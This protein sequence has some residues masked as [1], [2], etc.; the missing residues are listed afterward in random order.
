MTTFKIEPVIG[1]RLARVLADIIAERARQDAK[2]GEQNH[3]VLFNLAS[4]QAYQQVAESWKRI[5]DRRVGERNRDGFPPDKNAAWDGIIME[6]VAE[7][8][9]DGDPARIREEL[10][11]AA[12]TVVAAIECLDRKY[13]A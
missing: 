12:A 7:A 13:P 2:W 8:L 6:E 4:R 10:V 1:E 5:N 3:P 9:A 11:Q